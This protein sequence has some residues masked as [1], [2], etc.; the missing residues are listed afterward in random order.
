MDFLS[1]DPAENEEDLS[2]P[3]RE[4][5]VYISTNTQPGFINFWS[6]IFG[7][8][9]IV[10]TYPQTKRNL[11]MAQ[12]IQARLANFATGEENE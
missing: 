2:T 3:P 9:W 12:A 5:D 8:T 1:R 6:K 10:N 11:R 7:K 4:Y